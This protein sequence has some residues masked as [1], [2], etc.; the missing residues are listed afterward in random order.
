MKFGMTAIFLA[1]VTTIISAVLYIQ[2]TRK[3]LNQTVREKKK[4]AARPDSYL[5]NARIAY[6]FS[7]SLIG[8]AALYLFY[9][10]ITHNFHVRYVYQYSSRDLPSGILLS[11]FWAGQEGS[12][13]LWTLY[14]A[15]M[16]VVL[17]RTA[18]LFENVAMVLVNIVQIFFLL[19]LIQASPFRLMDGH[20]ADGA[21]LNPLLQNFWM[22]IHPPILFTGYAAVTFPFVLALASLLKK[23]YDS[24]I[25][26]A[27]PWIIFSALSLGAGII[28]GGFWAY[29]TLGW[30]G[31][32]GWDPVENS[33]LIPWLAIL[34]L[35]HGMIIQKR[36]GALRRINYLLAILAYLL[37]VYATFLTRS[38]VLADFSVHSFSDLGINSFLI[39]Y[40]VVMLVTSF[41]IFSARTRPLARQPIDLSALNREN[42]LVMSLWLFSAAAFLTFIGTSSPLI[43]G[44]LGKASQ[45]DTSFYNKMN[46]P[47]G[48]LMAL[49]LGVSPLLYWKE[50]EMRTVPQRMIIPVVIG[51]V[52][53]IAIYVT[54]LREFLLVLFIFT[55]V[56][57]VASNLIV[58]IRQWRVNWQSTAAP[59]THFGVGIIFIGIIV[60][61]NFAQNEQTILPKNK[62]VEVLGYRLTYQGLTSVSNGKNIATV[63]MSNG[64]QERLA[65]PRL[66]VSDYNRQLMREPDVVAGFFYDLYLSPLE[67]R[68]GHTHGQSVQIKKGE[69]TRV[70]GYDILFTGFEMASHQETEAFSVGALLEVTSNNHTEIVKPVLLIGEK[71]RES[72]PAALPAGKEDNGSTAPTVMLS[73]LNADEKTIELVFSAVEQSPAAPAQSTDELVVEFSKKPFMSILW[74]GTVIML[75]GTIIALTKR[76]SGN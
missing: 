62:P 50:K 20:P 69:R 42:A 22:I 26:T 64:R 28:I 25:Q 29:E 54:G 45:V 67:H 55:A 49:L 51:V 37:V 2:S 63:H 56:F 33:S 3:E 59:L 4:S 46:L 19:L 36:S 40:M 31:Y 5:H 9:L 38:G 12:F 74:I 60:S 35:L 76:I 30:G 66:Y 71:G 70:A 18:K 14:T 7:C 24:W 39:L 43:T 73:N 1:L 34:A 41:W 17:I 27:M 72:I 58:L 10:I 68:S 13:L 6:Y 53:A 44:L 8:I 61:G 75:L 21:G 48:I 23:E 15:I 32:W 47:V 11:T 52:A 57:A 16:G 65:T